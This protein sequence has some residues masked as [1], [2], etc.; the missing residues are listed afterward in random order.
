MY[1][2][3]KYCI[4][5][6]DIDAKTDTETQ[7]YVVGVSLAEDDAEEMLALQ[8]EE[9]FSDVE[10][11]YDHVNGKWEWKMDDEIGNDEL[12]EALNEHFFSYHIKICEL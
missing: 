6:I 4:E 9:D 12:M 3:I 2:V 8:V 1:A 7:F 11:I 5:D 10:D